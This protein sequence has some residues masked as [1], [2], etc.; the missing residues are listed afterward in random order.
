MNSLGFVGIVNECINQF[1]LQEFENRAGFPKITL[2]ARI[3]KPEDLNPIPPT[4]TK[5]GFFGFGRT[6]EASTRLCLVPYHTYRV[7]SIRQ[8]AKQVIQSNNE[9]G[10]KTAISM[11]APEAYRIQYLVLGQ[12]YYSDV[13]QRLLSCFVSILYDFSTIHFSLHGKEESIK[14]IESSDQ[15]L[16]PAV[17]AE[18]KLSGKPIYMFEAEAYIQSETVLSEDR[19]VSKRQISFKK[20]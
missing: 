18:L 2:E 6:E 20:K 9:T 11:F 14:L 4:P 7:E 19:L 5:P 3:L 13:G 8:R 16:D 10:P 17:V 12:S 1:L 15:A